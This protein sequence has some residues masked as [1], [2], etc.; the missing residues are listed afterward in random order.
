LLVAAVVIG[1]CGG[2][3][4]ASGAAAGC[5]GLRTAPHTTQFLTLFGATKRLTP[6]FVCVHFGAPQKISNND[7]GGVVWYYGHAVIGWNQNGQV[8]GAGFDH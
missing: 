2:K 7:R 6:A 3:S 1:G 5:A 8:D 4:A